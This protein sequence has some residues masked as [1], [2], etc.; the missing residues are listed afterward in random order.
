MS[1][2]LTVSVTS[3][4]CCTNTSLFC[5]TGVMAAARDLRPRIERCHG[6]SPWWSISVT[7]SRGVWLISSVLETEAT[8]VQIPP[9][10]YSA[11]RKSGHPIRVGS[12]KS[13]VQISPAL[14][15]RQWQRGYARDFE[16]RLRWF[17]STLP[18][19]SFKSFRVLRYTLVASINAR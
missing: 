11:V 7:G 19:F 17:E 1:S 5:S 2:N 18:R 6:S 16:S 12:G 9:L 8:R 15:I 13:R 14:L 4:L 10:R 3:L